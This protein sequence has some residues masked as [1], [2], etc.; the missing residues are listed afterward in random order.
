MLCKLI[1]S[2]LKIDA[3][4]NDYFTNKISKY[5]FLRVSLYILVKIH[6]THVL[7]SVHLTITALLQVIFLAVRQ[8]NINGFNV[9]FLSFSRYWLSLLPGKQSSTIYPYLMFN[10]ISIIYLTI[11]VN[12][13]RRRCGVCCSTQFVIIKFGTWLLAYCT[14]NIGLPLPCHIWNN[15]DRS[16]FDGKP[17]PLLV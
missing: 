7:M 3:W 5:I 4:A 17:I 8:Q 10:V 2:P 12:G 14:F 9:Y 11:D 16:I 13:D 6:L 1:F 15:W